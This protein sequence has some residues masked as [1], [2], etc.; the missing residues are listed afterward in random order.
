MTVPKLDVEQRWSLVTMPARERANEVVQEVSAQLLG[1]GP[2]IQQQQ[3]FPGIH[4]PVH[5]N[6]RQRH[7]HVALFVENEVIGVLRSE[8]QLLDFTKNTLSKM[9]HA[10]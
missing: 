8:T 3:L 6:K 10:T 9:K 4:Y 1:D 7:H 5:R 2:S